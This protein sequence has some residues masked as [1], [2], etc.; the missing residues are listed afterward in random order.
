[1]RGS[2]VVE[3]G[4]QEVPQMLVAARS[5]AKVITHEVALLRR[6]APQARA[7]AAQRR[8]GG[9]GRLSVVPATPVA[10]CSA[11][12]LLHNRFV[13]GR[14]GRV[15]EVPKQHILNVRGKRGRAVPCCAA[16]GAAPTSKRLVRI[17][18]RFQG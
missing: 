13:W 17:L 7:V 12:P 2:H 15:L 11:T 8:L 3:G 9:D 18:D 1:M 4:W 6:V 5:A 16:S 14:D 10:L